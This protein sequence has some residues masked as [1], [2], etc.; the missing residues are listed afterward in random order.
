MLRKRGITILL[1]ACMLITMFQVLPVAAEDTT[2][3]T[4]GIISY[5]WDFA[6]QTVGD[7]LTK[8]ENMS[9]DAEK[10]SNRV[11]KVENPQSTFNVVKDEKLGHNVLEWTAKT[12]E[13]NKKQN[14]FENLYFELPQPIKTADGPFKIT[15]KYWTQVPAKR[16]DGTC[17]FIGKNSGGSYADLNFGLVNW[18]NDGQNVYMKLYSNGS[19]YTLHNAGYELFVQ[20]DSNNNSIKDSK[21][22]YVTYEYY[23]DPATST[24]KAFYQPDYSSARYGYFGTRNSN[25]K[26]IISA[27]DADDVLVH[28]YEFATG[29]LP[30]EIDKLRFSSYEYYPVSEKASTSF[31]GEG[32]YKIDYVKIEQTTLA[33]ESTTPASGELFEGNTASVEFNNALDADTVGENTVKVTKNDE[34]LVYGTDYTA[35][36]DGAN[37][38]KLNIVFAK[39]A[40]KNEKYEVCITKDINNKTGYPKMSS[41]YIFNLVTNHTYIDYTFDFSNAA[42]KK[43]KDKTDVTDIS[44]F[45]TS[46]KY[47]DFSIVKDATLNKNVLQWDWK[48]N[49]EFT[50]NSAKSRTDGTEDLCYKLPEPIKPENGP[51]TIEM[52][53][54]VKD[55]P[56]NMEG[57]A[58]LVGANGSITKCGGVTLNYPSQAKYEK[59]YANGSEY[60]SGDVKNSA[61]K[62]VVFLTKSN[63]SGTVGKYITY[64]YVIDPATSTYRAYYKLDGY[65]DWSEPYEGTSGTDSKG[66]VIKYPFNL[67][68]LPDTISQLKF[69]LYQSVFSQDS[70]KTALA[71]ATTKSSTYLMDYVKVEQNPLAITE[72]KKTTNADGKTVLNVAFD[73]KIAADTVNAST[74]KLYKNGQALTYDTDYTV[75]V[76]DTTCQLMTITLDSTVPESDNIGLIIEDSINST[77]GYSKLLSSYKYNSNNRVGFTAV[78]YKDA[79]GAA[80]DA[81]SIIKDGELTVEAKVSNNTLQSYSEAVVL[82]TVFDSNHKLLACSINNLNDSL[83]TGSSADISSTFKNLGNDVKSV[84]MFVFNNMNE[85]KPIAYAYKSGN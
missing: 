68:T 74:V 54:Q 34:Q 50:L 59:L 17:S 64:K 33:V 7:D 4:S 65:K 28:S 83:A 49:Q 23:I 6:N 39:A 5:T 30:A 84:E 82:I 46:T 24:F 57:S 60:A 18:S 44:N 47:A 53:Y 11:T 21:E 38:K 32:K 22:I 2:A 16:V 70:D 25:N 42:V 80:I 36:V 43:Y 37:S 45:S 35:S 27:S 62:S 69:S 20:I 31:K 3:Q 79:S 15:M 72:C 40:A 56:R 76:D 10:G 78:G 29:T 12:N 67:T 26:Y 77:G 51:F 75:S 52:R 19:A 66:T 8:I 61:G 48:G 73:G 63:E 1:V 14:A 85:I 9:N 13:Y 58:L 71:N 55:E 41:D 81:P